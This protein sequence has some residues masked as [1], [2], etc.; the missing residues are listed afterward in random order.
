MNSQIETI[1]V[2]PEPATPPEP[3]TLEQDE[4]S[5]AESAERVIKFGGESSSLR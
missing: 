3:P 2:L 4:V 1:K 5:N